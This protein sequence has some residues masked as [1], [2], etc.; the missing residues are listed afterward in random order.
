MWGCLN[1]YLFCHR[2]YYCYYYYYNQLWYHSLSLSATPPLLDTSSIIIVGDAWR[3]ERRK[4]SRLLVRED[5]KIKD[6]KQTFWICYSVLC[7]GSIPFRTLTLHRFSHLVWKQ[8]GYPKIL[9][10]ASTVLHV[11]G[12]HVLMPWHTKLRSCHSQAAKWPEIREGDL[13]LQSKVFK[14]TPPA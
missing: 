7:C 5:D 11:D 1:D 14:E 9:F 4:R 12:R 8:Y 10:I 13:L 6:E 2:F 3:N